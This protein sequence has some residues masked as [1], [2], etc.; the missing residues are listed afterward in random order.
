MPVMPEPLEID[1]AQVEQ[2]I[3]RAE[4]GVLEAHEQKQLAPL[5]GTLLWLE[6][7]LLETR[8]GLSRLR[9]ILFG[10]RTEKR[11]RPP[12]P[13]PAEVPDDSGAD[14]PAQ[15]ATASPP[16]DAARAAPPAPASGEASKRP[17]PPGHG[18]RGAADYPGAEVVVCNHPEHQAGDLCP[19]CERGRLY[20]SRP[21]VRLRFDGQ[22]LA[23]VTRFEREQLRC[24]ACGAL[25]AAPL[26]AQAGE[27]TYAVSLKVNLALA[28]YHLGLPF[29]RIEA[30]QDLLGMPL[31]DAT[32]WD[33]VEQ[34]ADSAYPV[35]ESLKWLGAQQPLVYQDDTGARILS[36]M[37]ENQGEPAPERKAMQT[38]VLRFEGEHPICLYLSG[39]RHAGEN[40]DAVLA[41]RDPQRGP[42]LW[43]SDALAANT[44]TQHRHLTIDL[45]C[46]THGR[47]Q[48]VD[49]EEVF[50]DECA[51]VLE[52][53]GQVYKH[54]AYCTAQG[55]TP[56]QRL[57]YHQAHSAPVM[58]DLR[59]WM[60]DAL[61]AHRVEPNSRLGRAF[62]YM[63]KRWEALTGF[64][65]IPGAPLDNN[66]AE[67]ALKL[68][69]RYRKNS[70]FY[71]N[72]HSAYV[73][74][75]LTSLI[76]TCQLVGANPVDY[77]TALMENRSA[78]FADP[79]A[80]LPWNYHEP[81]DPLSLGHSPP[82]LGQLDR[83]GVAV[84]Q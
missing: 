61:K 79:A 30:L 65:R 45:S 21:L 80:W 47:R 67:Q 5:L 39:R 36:L 54:E 17:A 70:L 22:P 46:L 42:M 60:G 6:H 49:V 77:L 84:P 68:I 63:L 10:K 16:A 58:K 82:V 74:D 41:L 4:Q 66:L 75:V 62:D 8:M 32:Q 44:P 38:T 59:R 18:R 13:P 37:K 19:A 69:L 72:A 23:R 78:V 9:R 1:H 7:A 73:G 76:Q 15:G 25:F 53:I 64:L 34:V 27:Q 71:A 56:G 51:R 12:S 33:L 14:K 2:W 31:P 35:Y 29:T 52:A 40:L 28:H 55:L 43:M 50:P 81:P 57:A 11:K 20:P 26:P 48:F 83:L 24:G 3:E